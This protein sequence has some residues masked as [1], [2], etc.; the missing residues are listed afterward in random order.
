MED[1][2]KKK[3]QAIFSRVVKAGRR[4]YFFDVNQ[5]KKGDLYLIITES[6]KFYN[7]K[8]SFHFKKH[9]IFLYKEDFEEFADAFKGVVN[10]I[11]EN[12]DES[13]EKGGLSPEITDEDEQPDNM[14]SESESMVSKEEQK[15]EPV[16]DTNAGNETE[17]IV[18]PDKE[19]TDVSFDDLDKSDKDSDK[20]KQ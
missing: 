1:K 12:I 10:F 4:T 5:T 17:P 13:L 18:N 14:S 2:E 19:F 20:D 16:K 9:K 7:K 3:Q 6:K 15:N 8:G 11:H